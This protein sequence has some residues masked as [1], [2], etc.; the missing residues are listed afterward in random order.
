MNSWVRRLVAWRHRWRAEPVYRASSHLLMALHTS[1]LQ[2]K[3]TRVVVDRDS[4]EA[5]VPA[6]MAKDFRVPVLDAFEQTV[7]ELGRHAP[8]AI[9]SELGKTEWRTTEQ[10][11]QGAVVFR[12]ERPG[13]PA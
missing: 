12:V 5:W 6:D 2:A 3:A 8:Q 9:L 11:L 10:G 4:V 7:K 13:T 1:L